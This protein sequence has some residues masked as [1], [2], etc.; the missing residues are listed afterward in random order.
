MKPNISAYSA[1]EKRRQLYERQVELLNT[2]LA[3]G[4]ISRAQYDKSYGDLTAKM[5]FREQ[6]EKKA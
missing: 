2:F 4:A 1:E 5:G 6:P 3:S